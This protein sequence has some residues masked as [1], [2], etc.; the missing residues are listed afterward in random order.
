MKIMTITEFYDQ[1]LKVWLPTRWSR[2]VAAI[3]PV[4]AGSSLY[5]PNFL[6]SMHLKLSEQTSLLL[7]LSLPP[8]ILFLGT[9][10][11]LSLVVCHFKN[12]NKNNDQ[13][14]KLNDMQEKI[15]NLLFAKKSKQED[16]RSKFNLNEEEANY[17]LQSLYDIGFITCPGPYTTG[18]FYW[19]IA[20]PGR[21]HIMLKMHI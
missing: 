16:I 2:G 17:Y 20:Q 9:L 3:T 5:L 13:D 14:I 4:L 21:E 15:L 18:P 11:I 1:I 19:S 10:L 8:T 12:A 7:R 6:D